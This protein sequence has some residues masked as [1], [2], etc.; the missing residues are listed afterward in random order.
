VSTPLNIYAESQM[1]I[2]DG[3]EL[4]LIDFSEQF[5][6]FS[7]YPIVHFGYHTVLEKQLMA[8]YQ[9]QQQDNQYL[10]IE[11][12]EIDAACFDNAQA[13]DLGFAHRRHWMLLPASAKKE[14]CKYGESDLP[15]YRYEA[16]R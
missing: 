1:Y 16:E 8:A 14:G 7:P 3:A 6:L 12:I 13:I 15:V 9:W 4:A 2:D 10:L 11:D 5:I